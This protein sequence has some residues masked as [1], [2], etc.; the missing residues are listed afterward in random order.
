MIWFFEFI[1]IIDVDLNVIVGGFGFWFF[2]MFLF[3]WKKSYLEEDKVGE[4]RGLC[5]G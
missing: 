3:V 4:V 5:W 2:L 1:W